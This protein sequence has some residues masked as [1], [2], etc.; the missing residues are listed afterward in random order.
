MIAGPGF[1]FAAANYALCLV[2]AWEG[3]WGCLRQAETMLCQSFFCSDKCKRWHAFPVFTEASELGHFP[4]WLKLSHTCLHAC[5][6]RQYQLGQT[7][8]AIREMRGLLRKY[9]NFTE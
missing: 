6:C 2:S 3:G 9:P 1:S 4:C 8:E 7:D 5:L